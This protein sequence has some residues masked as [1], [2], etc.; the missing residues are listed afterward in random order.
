MGEESPMTYQD[1]R[2]HLLFSGRNQEVA[3]RIYIGLEVRMEHSVRVHLFHYRWPQ[4]PLPR[5]QAVTIVNF[6]IRVFSHFRKKHGPRSFASLAEVVTVAANPA[7]RRSR[8]GTNCRKAKIHELYQLFGIT[9]PISS[10]MF[11]M[12]AVANLM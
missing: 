12:E 1:G 7:E 9:A 4:Q 2:H 8:N 5:N 11:G 10:F 6:G 3:E